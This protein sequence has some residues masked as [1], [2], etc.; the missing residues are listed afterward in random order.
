VVEGS[1]EHHVGNLH[2]ALG[3]L[4]QDAEAVEAGHLYIEENQVGRM[5]LDEADGLEAIF[6]LGDQMD[7]RKRFEKEGEFL[8]GGLFV[9]NDKRVDGH[10]MVT[11][12]ST[13]DSLQ[14]KGGKR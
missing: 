6:S 5:F 8:T 2:F 9:V 13:V 1:S 11:E 4:L 7:F 14:A 3:E 10:T 12:K